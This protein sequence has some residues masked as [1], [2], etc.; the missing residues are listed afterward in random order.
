MKS[1]RTGDQNAPRR[2]AV[3][4]AKSHFHHLGWV[5]P[6]DM[7]MV[8]QKINISQPGAKGLEGGGVYGCR[9]VSHM[10]LKHLINAIHVWHKA[11][12]TIS[13]FC[14]YYELL[15]NEDE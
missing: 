3:Y 5:A 13:V 4:K 8:E 2:A 1:C 10:K 12:V 14:D 15:D 7:H 9:S 11:L 6:D